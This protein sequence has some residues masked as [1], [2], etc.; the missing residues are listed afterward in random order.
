MIG[1]LHEVSESFI[2]NNQD[3]LMKGTGAKNKTEYNKRGNEKS[4][5][6]VAL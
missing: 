3:E 5:K 2:G 6:N 1:I 4:E